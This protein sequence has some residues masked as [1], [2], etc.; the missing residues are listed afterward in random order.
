MKCV[1]EEPACPCG[2]PRHQRL[3]PSG[4]HGTLADLEDDVLHAAGFIDDEQEVLTVE[5][6]KGFG[7]F[8][9]GCPRA[10][11]NTFT[12]RFAERWGKL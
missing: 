8:L 9:P 7:L 10:R 12:R 2:V 11:P 6:L 5:P 1:V 3:G 4:G